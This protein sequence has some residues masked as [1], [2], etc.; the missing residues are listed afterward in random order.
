MGLHLLITTNYSLLT[1]I[2]A[3]TKQ[4]KQSM[5]NELEKALSSMKGAVLASFNKLPVS[6]DWDLRK[7]LRGQGISY[8]VVKKSLFARVLKQLNLPSVNLDNANGNIG[9]LIS[10]QDEVM[11]AKSLAEFAKGKETVSMLAGFM[12]VGGSYEALD[13][14]KVKTL[15]S[16]PGKQELLGTLVRTIKNPVSR[17]H[18]T[19]SN[20]L[21]GLVNVLNGIAKSKS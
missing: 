14:A 11:P 12:N 10:S 2:M 6:Q 16:L 8:R 3:K 13:A 20:P 1:I 21:R 5:M 17:L 15:A 19:L 18:G 4:Q 9:L 7:K